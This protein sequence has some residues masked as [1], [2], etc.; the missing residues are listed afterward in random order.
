M[1][2][3]VIKMAKL[4][5]GVDIRRSHLMVIDVRCSILSSRRWSY[6][7]VQVIKIKIKIMTKH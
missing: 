1:F 4:F 7:W 2:D 6:R 3:G 5:Y